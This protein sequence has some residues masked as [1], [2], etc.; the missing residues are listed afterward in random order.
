MSR[1]GRI[2]LTSTPAR[3]D[4]SDLIRDVIR[5]LQPAASQAISFYVEGLADLLLAPI[6]TSSQQLEA[7]VRAAGRQR[8]ASEVEMPRDQ[9]EAL[10]AAIMQSASALELDLPDALAIRPAFVSARMLAVQEEAL[11]VLQALDAGDPGGAA[12]VREFAEAIERE[13]S[14]IDRAFEDASLAAGQFIGEP[15]IAVF[16]QFSEL[17]S[18]ADAGGDGPLAQTLRGLA[19][20]AGQQI[21]AE[22][23]EAW[24]LV[25]LAASMVAL[26]Q[27]DFVIEATD[28]TQ[29]RV[30]ARDAQSDTGQIVVSA[31]PESG[32]IEYETTGYEGDAC[33][34]PEARFLSSL[35]SVLGAEITASN[36][37]HWAL[38][39]QPA[40]PRAGISV[41][42]PT[43][44][45]TRLGGLR[46]RLRDGGRERSPDRER[47]R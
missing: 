33:A 38:P 46:D 11:R 6:E 37:T 24:S 1:S 47:E 21:R 26:E 35:A 14:L 25:A 17:L 13:Q 2:Q 3:M 23:E 8:I 28:A 20:E 41:G 29:G 30:T 22:T 34:G 9:Y 18:S 32:Q 5:A 39:A 4:Y 27:A 43:T 16:D 42:L 12:R 44:E 45:R 7:E 36:L 31:N 19:A 10:R 40:D 15:A